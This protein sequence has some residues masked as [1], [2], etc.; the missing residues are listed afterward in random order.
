MPVKDGS[1][2]LF[3]EHEVDEWLAAKAAQRPA[4]GAAREVAQA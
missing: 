3:V 4:R 1:K 2:T